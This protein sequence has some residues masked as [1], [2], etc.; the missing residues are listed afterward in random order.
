MRNCIDWFRE[1]KNMFIGLA[2]TVVILFALAIV[3]D[4]V[5]MP[6]YTHHGAEKELPDVTELSFDEAKEVLEKSGFKIVKEQ[7]MWESTYPESTIIQQH[8]LPYSLVKKGRRIYVSVSAGERPVE[9]PDVTG[10]SE[11]DAF[12]K[13]RES[14]LDPEEPPYYEYDN[15][16]PRGVVCKQSVPPGTNVMENTKISIT[17]S[18]GPL[19]TEFIV[20]DLVGRS[21]E[22]AQKMLRQNGLILGIVEYRVKKDL[23]P[24]TVIE[25]SRKAGMHVEKGQSVNIVLSKLEDD[26]WE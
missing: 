20:P 12:Y 22:T 13:L 26:T 21:L 19:P 18:N 2:A 6:L 7:E 5:F 9:V 14:G 23:I 11:R 4:Y 17:V 1:K 15:Y 10:I 3:F 24:N 25:Q 8:P 16:R